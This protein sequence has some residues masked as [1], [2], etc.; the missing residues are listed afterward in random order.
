[1]TSPLAV[2]TVPRCNIPG[3]VRFATL[4]LDP[5]IVVEAITSE[6]RDIEIVEIFLSTT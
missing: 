4:I 6:Q 1:M 3:Y 5:Y 2:F